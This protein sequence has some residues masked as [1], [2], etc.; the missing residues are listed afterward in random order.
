IMH[1]ARQ[2]EQEIDRVL[3]QISGVQQLKGIEGVEE[4]QEIEKEGELGER[5]MELQKNLIMSVT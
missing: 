4:M 3:Q 1:W 5:P 2:I